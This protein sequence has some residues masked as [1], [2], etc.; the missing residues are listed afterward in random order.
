MHSDERKKE[1]R[2]I[3][4]QKKNEFY[5]TRLKSLL[6]QDMTWYKIVNYHVLSSMIEFHAFHFYVA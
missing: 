2:K 5:Q 1:K 3:R 4:V 6:W